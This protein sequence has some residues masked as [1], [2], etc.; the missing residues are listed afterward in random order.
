MLR[1][2]LWAIL[3]C[4]L[5]YSPLAVAQVDGGHTG[6]W[7]DPAHEGSGFLI[8]VLPDQRAV[9]YWY[10]Y[11]EEGAQQW[12]IGN[13]LVDGENIVVAELLRTSGTQFGDDFAADDVLLEVAGSAT[14]AFSGCDSASVDFQIGDF[15]DRQDLI[16]LSAIYGRKCGQALSAA[17][18]NQTGS[19]YNVGR[20]G[21]GFN[22]EV[23]DDQR[24]L[25][26]WFTYDPQG[27][28]LWLI[29]LGHM[30]AEHIY[31]DQLL[32]TSGGRLSDDHDPA[33]VVRTLWGSL[34]LDLSCNNG[35]FGYDAVQPGY[36][37]GSRSLTRLS[38]IQGLQCHANDFAAVTALAQLQGNW[39]SDGF[40]LYAEVGAETLRF[41][42]VTSASCL[43]VL[44]APTVALQT[45]LDEFLI[46]ADG[47]RLSSRSFDSV[48][49]V[50]FV[51]AATAPP[52]CASG[53]TAFSNNFRSNYDVFTNT[54]A[55]LYATFDIR[56]VDWGSLR[57][58]ADTQI[59]QVTTDGGLFNLFR[60]MLAPLNDVHVTLNGPGR[61]Y[62]SGINSDFLALRQLAA[63][64]NVD[65]IINT[66]Y[67]DQP[68]LSAIRGALSYGVIGGQIG[69]VELKTFENLL[70]NADSETTRQFVEDEVDRVL[71]DLNGRG[72]SGLIIDVR[73]NFGG[74][75]RLGLLI[76]NRFA[77]GRQR[78][79]FSARLPR[80]DGLTAAVA[81]LIVPS[82][83]TN[84][85]GP[86]AV[87]SSRLTVS[88]AESFV[89][90][91][92]A[93][94]Q[95]TLVGAPTLGALSRTERVLPNGWIVSITPSYIESPG[96]ERFEAQGIP[97]DI[98][99]TTF[100]TVDIGLNRDS[101]IE[102]A[103]S[104]LL[105]N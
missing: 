99:T 20:A 93:L 79:A 77:Q 23:L 95:V 102:A 90:A 31:V 75:G 36:G 21:E 98:A 88:A 65:R 11:D 1:S 64:P 62:Q 101:A 94:P 49:N 30:A 29:A 67:L 15:S 58:Q 24:V 40:G 32:S 3:A 18:L 13:G 74:N 44:A 12:F 89:Q 105:D 10:T 19:W 14:F 7:Y 104:A 57:A 33:S 96:G 45:E 53:I 59:G 68:P 6:S 86:I 17:E 26:T 52:A 27:R 34:E 84:Y 80:A 55:E 37:S 72:L 70:P 66:V 69:Y 22:V 82:A 51:R 54:F 48:T 91:M 92:R 97:P 43:Q 50:E 16:R 81:Q 71:S 39:V 38:L 83:R 85:H 41:F 60:Q 28:Q 8:E 42:E 25:V 76:V 9:V 73:R 103:L 2:I 61:N 56:G 63:D 5:I 47:N 35:E 46:S 4:T 78:I 87:L 100:S